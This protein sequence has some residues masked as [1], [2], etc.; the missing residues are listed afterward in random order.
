MLLVVRNGATL[1]RT[2]SLL[3]VLR[4]D[5]PEIRFT[6]DA[7][8]SFDLG[9]QRHIESLGF[10]VLSWKEATDEHFDVILATQASKR[11]AELHGFKIVCAHGA[12][13]NRLVP[14]STGSDTV[15]TGLVRDQLMVGGE[16]IPDLIFVSHAEQIDR[17]RLG[18]PEAA[19]R[20]V[21]LGDPVFYRI[22]ESEFARDRFRQRFE[23]TGR[24]KL[25]VVSSTWGPYGG[26][27][28]HDD[29]IPQLLVQLPVHE[30]RLA[31]ILHPNIWAGHTPAEIKLF[32]EDYCDAG[33]V[34]I[35]PRTPWEA[36]VIA[37]DIVLGDHGSVSYYGA[38]LGRPLLLIADGS[39]ELDPASPPARLCR[40][41][42]HL[43]LTKDLLPQIDRAFSTH[44]PAKAA[45]IT[46]AM[47]QEQDRSWEIFRNAILQ[48]AARPLPKGRPRMIR[49]DDPE[50]SPS[51][52]LT[53]WK[54]SPKLAYRENNPVIEIR[55]LPKIVARE[56][57]A[58]RE[59]TL[60]IADAAEY[61]LTVTAQDEVDRAC[62]DNTDVM[63][64]MG[65][66]RTADGEQWASEIFTGRT[67]TLAGYVGNGGCML[68]WIDGPGL[69][70][71]HGDVLIAAAAAY[72]WRE[73]E[74]PID[75]PFTVEVDV[76]GELIKLDMSPLEA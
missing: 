6:I 57:D 25:V 31:A 61:Y 2:L 62:R 67:A 22:K 45:A 32:L 74:L 49:V 51:R 46:E 20:A 7:G 50:P 72:R 64:H 65:P 48:A 24:Q 43:D 68:R 34:Y 16:V 55:C 28:S 21:V 75:L 59:R 10:E 52:S 69:F 11:L 39:Q 18:C 54:V 76:G 41:G 5:V 66:L 13:Y 8:S 27:G 38:A 53:A 56:V 58:Y 33:L 12:G 47:F 42:D 4:A 63:L 29:L 70:V 15:A 17:L 19:E 35:P 36:A 30:Y 26:L 3:Q 1:D 23:L 40:E 60:R 14:K 37:A 71:A 73:E 44:D 9:L